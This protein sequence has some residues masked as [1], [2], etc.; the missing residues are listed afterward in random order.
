MLLSEPGILGGVQRLE[1]LDADTA[2][3]LVIEIDE[4]VALSRPGPE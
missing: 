1:V 4:S 3:A 2:E